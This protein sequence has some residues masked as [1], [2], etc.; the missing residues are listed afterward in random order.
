MLT[1]FSYF[2]LVE[3]FPKRGCVVCNLLLRDVERLLDSILY[4][5]VNDPE[6]QKTFRASR[7]LCNQHGWQMAKFG[8]V[9]SIAVLYEAS[10]DEVLSIL[11]QTAPDGN[12]Q[13]GL[14]RLLVPQ[15]SNAALVEALEPARPCIVCKMESASEAQY[16]R[17]LSEHLADDKLQGAYRASDGLCLEHFKQALRQTH[18]VKRSQLLVEIQTNIWDRLRDELREF[19]RKYDYKHADEKMGAEGDSWRRAVARL[20]G[21]EGVF[22]V[23]RAIP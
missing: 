1:S 20:G 3:S 14:A 13:H 16:I 12:L 5:Y 10:V 4:E 21:E 22:G 17:I 11:H 2:D 15:D 23:R 9:L 19:M 6:T 8:N 18:D 7:G